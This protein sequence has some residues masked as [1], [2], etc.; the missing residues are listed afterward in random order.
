MLVFWE[1][2]RLI[3]SCYWDGVVGISVFVEKGRIE[4]VMVY[5][6]VY[7][8]WGIVLI[9]V[10]LREVRISLGVRYWCLFLVEELKFR[11]RV[12]NSVV[13]GLEF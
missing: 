5:V 13:G 1:I 3:G 8:V 11:K 9:F 4:L 12:L 2:R 6:G 10:D 7:F